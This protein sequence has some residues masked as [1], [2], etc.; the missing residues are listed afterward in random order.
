MALKSGRFALAGALAAVLAL[1]PGTPAGAQAV[2]QAVPPPGLGELQSAL[3]ILA[4]E[5]QNQPALLRAAWASIELEDYPAAEGYLRRAEAVNPANGEVSAGLATLALRQGDPIAATRLFA[6]AEAQGAPMAPHASNRGLALDLVGS[7]VAA[8]GFYRQAI[9]FANDAE[10]VRRLALSQAISGDLPSSEATLLPLLQR[11]DLAAYRTRAFALAIAGKGE[12][13]V[14]IAQTMLP[15]TLSNRM[16]PYLRYMPR[17]TRAQQAGAA[18]LGRFPP[19]AEIGR[20]SPEIAAIAGQDAPVQVAARTADSRLEPAGEP[21]GA[22]NR[23]SR[24]QRTREQAEPPADERVPIGRV[25]DVV[26]T[27][28]ATPPPAEPAP[29]PSFSVA[30]PVASQPQPAETPPAPPSLAEAFADF[31]LPPSEV[32]PAAGAVDITRIDPP[33]ERAAQPVA[34]PAAKPPAPKPPAHPRRFWVQVA[35]G[36]DAD[37]LKWD[38]RRIK[39]EGGDLLSS[40]DAF[41][42]RWGQANRLL[43]GPYPTAAAAQQAVTALKA[44]GLDSFTF[45]SA[46]GEAV[47]PLR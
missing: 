25:A 8:Q 1:G 16:A 9:Q 24:R 6:Q 30:Q 41:S 12:E 43:T 18:N 37:A 15:A 11:S 5:P 26:T 22:G 4:R 42:A 21:L 39:R 7:N 35:T 20:D 2:V 31:S 13:A 3:R 44:K 36:R 32:V 23:E 10:T 33:R 47:T 29:Q 28:I 14:S 46:E 34:K 19:A 17:L 45:T 38:W 27:P 40:K